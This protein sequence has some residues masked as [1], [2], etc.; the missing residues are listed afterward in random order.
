M[1]FIWGCLRLELSCFWVNM[2]SFAAPLFIVS[3]LHTVSP[4]HE[5]DTTFLETSS[6][7]QGFIYDAAFVWID[8]NEV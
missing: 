5:L 8:S 6:Q 7:V 2:V 1:C 4:L 3:V